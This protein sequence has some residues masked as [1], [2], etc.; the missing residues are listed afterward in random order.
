MLD[1][2]AWERGK[3]PRSHTPVQRVLEAHVDGRM[4]KTEMHTDL[5]GSAPVSVGEMPP[6]VTRTGARTFISAAPAP[7]ALLPGLCPLRHAKDT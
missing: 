2:S 5:K 7:P 1:L 3:P 4:R 6:C